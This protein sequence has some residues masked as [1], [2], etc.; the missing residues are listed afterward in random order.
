MKINIEI[1]DGLCEDEITIKCKSISDE[2]RRIEQAVKGESSVQPIVFYK[3]NVEF[4]FPLSDVLFF[5][6]SNDI[7]YAHTA[8]DAFKIKLKLRELVDA[9]PSKFIRISK[10]AI[11]NTAHILSID[12]NLSSSSLVRFQKSHKQVYV[13]RLYYKVLKQKLNER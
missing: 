11:V 4:Y 7:L 12:K 13:S 8:G 3:N 1:V 9:L 10:G 5:E 2:I 6:T